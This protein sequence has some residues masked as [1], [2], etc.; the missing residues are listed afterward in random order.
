MPGGIP[1]PVPYCPKDTDRFVFN[2]TT[3]NHR[4][5]DTNRLVARMSLIPDVAER[6]ANV[7]RGKIRRMIE[8]R[9]GRPDESTF[10]W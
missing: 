7:L 4:Y 1:P 6:R 3:A 9:I 8:L 5:A 10:H 2:K